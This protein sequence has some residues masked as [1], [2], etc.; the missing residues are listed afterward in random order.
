ML[1]I[2]KN[3]TLPSFFDLIAPHSCRGC[4]RLGNVLCDRCKKYIT[5]NHIDFCPFCKNSLNQCKCQKRQ[6]IP[7]VFIVDRRES[8]VGTLIQDLKYHSVRAVAPILAELLDSTL[9]SFKN[10]VIL[11]PLPTINQHIRKRGLDHTY[12][13]AKH[14]AKLRG[15]KYQ[16]SHLL[17][18][19]KNT[20]QVGSNRSERLKQAKNAYKLNPKIPIKSNTTYLLLDDIWTTG[21]SIKSAIEKLRQGGVQN[22]AIIVLALS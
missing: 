20:V 17:L 9:P 12:L 7:P 8:I 6:K 21:A 19:A 4:G 13:I 14:L 18:R 11:V 15:K 22:L 10:P 3:T 5:A 2:V 1:N 16:V